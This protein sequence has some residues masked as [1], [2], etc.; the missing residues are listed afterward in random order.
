MDV[1]TQAAVARALGASI[2]DVAKKEFVR[3]SR[4]LSDQRITEEILL[5]LQALEGLQSNERPVY[6]AWDSLFYLTWFQPSQINL[7]YTLARRILADKSPLIAGKGRLHVGDFGCGAFAMQF[8]LALAV[9]E[10]QEKRDGYPKIAIVSKDRS[11]D[12]RYIGKKMWH[13]FIREIRDKGKYPELEQLW[14]VCVAIKILNRHGRVAATRWLTVLHVAYEENAKEVK[15]RLDTA[16]SKWKPDVVLVTAHPMAYEWA[17]FL[18][19]PAAYAKHEEFL[20]CEDLALC[21]G[22][23]VATTK[24]RRELHKLYQEKIDRLADSRGEKEIS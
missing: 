14:E 15:S 11:D 4:G 10:T 8:G 20:G 19:E 2:A 23:L 12:M 1:A 7:A 24:F 13:R 5:A 21:E 6:D 22:S 9:A 18:D 17:Y 16:V 3:L